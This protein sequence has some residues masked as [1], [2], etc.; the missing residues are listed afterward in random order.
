MYKCTWYWGPNSAPNWIRCWVWPTTPAGPGVHRL[1]FFGIRALWRCLSMTG[2][3][4]PLEELNYIV[5]AGTRESG[6]SAETRFAQM[7]S[8]FTAQSQAE[9]AS[10]AR[11]L[12]KLSSLC[13]EGP[14]RGRRILGSYSVYLRCRCWAKRQHLLRVPNSTP[15]WGSRKQFQR[16]LWPLAAVLRTWMCFLDCHELHVV[17]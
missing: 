2:K 3:P 9:G 12:K 1:F 4:W 6:T 17:S 8:E 16:S 10:T 14:L 15:G 13:E 11:F 5:S 7:E